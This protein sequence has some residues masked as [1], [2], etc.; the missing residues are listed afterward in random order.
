MAAL[1]QAVTYESW[2]VLTL[3]LNTEFEWHYR[4]QQPLY[5]YGFA[6]SFFFHPEALGREASKAHNLYRELLTDLVPGNTL[7]LSADELMNK[8]L[9]AQLLMCLRVAQENE[10]GKTYSI[11]P[12][13]GRFYGFRVKTL[14]DRAYGNKTFGAGLAHAFH[15]SREEFLEKLSPRLTFIRRNFWGGSNYVWDSLTSW[16]PPE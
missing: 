1:T 7:T 16:S 12:D 3:L 14:F 13:Y 5:S 6:L 11:W 15:E 2:D 8:Y 4:S 9:Q 10:K